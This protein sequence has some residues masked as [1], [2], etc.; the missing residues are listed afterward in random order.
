MSCLA[1]IAYMTISLS[2]KNFAVGVENGY[3]GK[4]YDSV[5]VD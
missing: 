2:E 5:V 4:T 3:H 1:N